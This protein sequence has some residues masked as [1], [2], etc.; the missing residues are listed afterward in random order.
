[1]K[2]THKNVDQ[3]VGERSKDDEF[4]LNQKTLQVGL[5]QL[6]VF[7]LYLKMYRAVVDGFDK[8]YEDRRQS[9][10]DE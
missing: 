8:E 3:N 6:E 5:A 10:K 1:M 4:N 7:S 9:K 2:Y